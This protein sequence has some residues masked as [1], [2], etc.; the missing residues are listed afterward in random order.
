[1]FTNN[2]A[3]RDGCVKLSEL[4]FLS[5]MIAQML[6]ERHAEVHALDLTRFPLRRFAP[7]FRED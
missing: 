2:I 4:R 7:R 6:F 3:Q 5:A 1:M